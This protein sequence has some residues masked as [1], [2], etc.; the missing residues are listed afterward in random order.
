MNHITIVE[1]RVSDLANQLAKEWQAEIIKCNLEN[2]ADSESAI[3]IEPATSLQGQTVF[4]IH[5]FSSQT[6]SS[7]IFN[8][9]VNNQILDF[10]LTVG[11]LKQLKPSKIIALLPY[12]PYARQE[13]SLDGKFIGPFEVFTRL[14]K[15]AGVDA[16]LTCDLHSIS[17]TSLSAL[18]LRNLNLAPFWADVLS[19]YILTRNKKESVCIVSPDLGGRNRAQAVA[20]KLGLDLAVIQKH[21]VSADHAIALELDG[22]VKNKIAIIVDDIVD[23][24]RTSTSACNLLLE[25][26]AKKV[27]GCFSHTVLSAG[28]QER[29]KTSKFESIFVTNTISYDMAQLHEK[30]KVVTLDGYLKDRIQEL[31]ETNFQIS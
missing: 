6:S 12:L 23:T 2:F 21:R 27:L 25:S 3:T 26:G 13:K 20:S 30:F 1:T 7:E 31:A 24:A 10:L 11:Q 22:N 18:P 14:L 8:I 19:K 29:L 5:H 16:I 4:F 17:A 15:Q 9:S 28:A